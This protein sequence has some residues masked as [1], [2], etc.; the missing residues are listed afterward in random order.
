MTE[1]NHLVQ[2][3]PD[4]SE[5]SGGPCDVTEPDRKVEDEKAIQ[6]SLQE[7]EELKLEGNDY[8]R[9]GKWTEALN[10]YRTGLGR[11]PRRKKNLTSKK[12]KER[13]RDLTSGLDEDDDQGDDR[14]LATGN[15]DGQ[16]PQPPL[17]EVEKECAKVR[18]VL[19]ANI[20][21]CHMKLEEYKEAVAACTEALLDDPGYVKALQRRAACNQKIGTWS[22]L[23]SAQED[24]TALLSVLPPSS[25]EIGEMRRALQSIKPR[26]EA[27]QKA[28]MA[29]MM[30]K[31]KGL[32]NSVLGHFG[33]STDNFKFE[34]NGQ[35]GY[36]MN[37]VR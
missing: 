29:E 22:S 24:Y 1:N 27:A 8:F 18:A 30:D 17:T 36:S 15:E 11:L 7:A 33:L 12:G 28:E 26:I 16:E 25:H 3:D 19:S 14:P 20:G 13:E 6:Q 23:T 37:F 34:P 10:A 31:L 5:L 4:G 2:S 35:G 32:G 21:A 9:A